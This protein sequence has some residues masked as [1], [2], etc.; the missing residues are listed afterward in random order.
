MKVPF[1]GVPVQ[2]QNLAVPQL[3]GANL[4]IGENCLFAAI[5]GTIYKMNPEFNGL[6]TVVLPTGWSVQAASPFFT[7]GISQHKLY[8]YNDQ[9]IQYNSIDTI[10]NY[11]S[12]YMWNMGGR[13]IVAGSN[14]TVINATNQQYNL[15][16]TIYV[17]SDNPMAS[18]ASNASKP[19]SPQ[20]L[21]T[22]EFPSFS[23]EVVPNNQ[24]L[25][26]LS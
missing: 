2:F 3:Q 5:G 8:R 13:L 23:V 4:I 9:L 11:Q 22:F 18:N 20:T 19:A 21:G 17:F 14:A 6:N 25:C 26:L 15:T 16:M 1:A 10:K 7:Y 24:Y 12:F